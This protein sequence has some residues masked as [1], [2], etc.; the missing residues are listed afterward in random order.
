MTIQLKAIE[1][2]FHVLLFIMLYKGVLM[3]SLWIKPWCVII[4]MKAIEQYIHMLFKVFITF[5]S[6]DKITVLNHSPMK[7]EGRGFVTFNT[8][9]FKRLMFFLFHRSYG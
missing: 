2:Y 5:Q 9:F 7:D 8:S 4:Q 6:V 3:L 1:Q